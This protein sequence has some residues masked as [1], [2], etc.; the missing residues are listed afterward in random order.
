M[1]I[2]FFVCILVSAATVAAAQTKVVTNDDLA[3]YRTVRIKAEAELRENY[4]KLGFSSPEE[5]AKRNERSIKE[6]AETS[7]RI[8]AEKAARQ[9]EDAE[10]RAVEYYVA[11]P[12][13]E[14]VVINGRPN[15]HY[16]GYYWSVPRRPRGFQQQGYFAGGQFWTTG[17][18]TPS[19]PL[20]SRPRN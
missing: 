14:I 10:K 16:G 7:A 18:S 19:R 5:R 20:I 12:R 9:R 11:T 3:K 8:R 1:K 13:T 6:L 2:L 4:A 15:Y 17:S